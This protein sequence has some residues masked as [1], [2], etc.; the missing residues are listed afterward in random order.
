VCAHA[1]DA[2]KS[3]VRG[4]HLGAAPFA[5][6]DDLERNRTRIALFVATHCSAGPLPRSGGTLGFDGASP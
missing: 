2:D 5:A 4:F 3:V 6:M 1:A